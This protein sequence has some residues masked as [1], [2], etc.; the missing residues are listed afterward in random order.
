MLRSTENK[1]GEHGSCSMTWLPYLVKL[2]YLKALLA[3]P[4]VS[5]V[6]MM[7]QVLI[8]V[9]YG[10]RDVDHSGRHVTKSDSR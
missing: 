2:N 10:A 4:C 3:V 5:R 1:D 7:Q 9:Y 8:H 6:R